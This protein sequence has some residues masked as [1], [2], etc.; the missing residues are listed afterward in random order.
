MVGTLLK[1]PVMTSHD[2]IHVS[3]KMANETAVETEARLQKTARVRLTTK[4]LRRGRQ[5][6][7]RWE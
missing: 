3:A 6:Y 4:P 2:G 7:S 5:D 1:L